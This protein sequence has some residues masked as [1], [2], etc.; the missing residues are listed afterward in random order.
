MEKAV[1]NGKDTQKLLGVNDRG[2]YF[3]QS[4]DIR[5]KDRAEGITKRLRLGEVESIPVEVAA[6][7]HPFGPI[8]W[9]CGATFRPAKLK[10]LGW[11]PK[12]FD[13][14]ALMEDEGGERA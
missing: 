4:D 8:M 10:S 5:M 2:Y 11:R 3:V 12:E 14:R 9:G 7:Y 1:S 6:G 13:W